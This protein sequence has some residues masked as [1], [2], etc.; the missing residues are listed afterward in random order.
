MLGGSFYYN[1]DRLK[2]KEF[3]NLIAKKKA[4]DK[5]EAWIREL[6][7]RDAEDK[8]WREKMGKVRDMKREEAEREAMEEKKRRDGRSDD[9]K[10][11]IETV[12]SKLKDAKETELAREAAEQQPDLVAS[13]RQRRAEMEKRQEIV[14]REQQ[15][16]KENAGMGPD[17]RIWG[18]GG[19]GLFG[20]RR[21]SKLWS[22]PKGDDSGNDK[23][24]NE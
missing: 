12:K 13:A 11:L 7:A 10:G 14:K 21:I 6:E 24:G 20:W 17:T 1:A 19:G 8:E 3:T 18:E 2:R 23:P 15:T 4:Q 5:K 22:K 9:G 16:V